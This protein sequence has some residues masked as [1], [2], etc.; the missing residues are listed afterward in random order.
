MR[1]WPS[2]ANAASWC[3]ATCSG[4]SSNA[5]ESASKKTVFATEQDRADIRHDDIEA[6]KAEID[7]R[8]NWKLV[9][10]SAA[11][12]TAAGLES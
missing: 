2:L 9:E 10:Q 3:H 1:C 8:A 6:R 11:A 4:G 12:F 7:R 5:K